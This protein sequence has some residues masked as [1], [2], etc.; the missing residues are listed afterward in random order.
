[1]ADAVTAAFHKD[2]RMH[3]WVCGVQRDRAVKVRGAVGDP[4]CPW[5][6]I[7]V[8]VVVGLK[9]HRPQLPKGSSVFEHRHHNALQVVFMRV[10]MTGATTAEVIRR[11]KEGI[12][13]KVMRFTFDD[14]IV[15]MGG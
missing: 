12:G 11:M 3:T 15:D 14:R 5:H 7:V 9:L 6:S 13:K 1:M 4:S 2:N 8:K 10:P